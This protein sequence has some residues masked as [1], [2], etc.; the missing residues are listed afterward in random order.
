MYE[1]YLQDIEDC[2][3]CFNCVDE[4]AKEYA[5]ITALE[6]WGNLTC[7]NWID[8]HAIQLHIALKKQCGNCCPLIYEVNLIE[9]WV[10]AETIEVNLLIW[11]GLKKTTKKL[12][13][14]YDEYSHD[15]KVDLSN[16]IDCCNCCDSYELLID[17][18]VG[19]DNIPAEFCQW[20]CSM[21]K[22]FIQVNEVECAECGSQDDIAIIE[23]DG[24]KDLASTFKM[25]AMQYFD[26]LISKY[27]L[28]EYKSIKDWTVYR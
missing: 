16:M 10:R 26:L 7:G 22:V 3:Q 17:Y 19:T 5:L 8:L 9:E 21:M 6:T 18:E 25:M 12:D 27:S 24:A 4:K 28:C 23:V 20:F 14:Y 15:L 1:L 11:N 13:Y 2:C